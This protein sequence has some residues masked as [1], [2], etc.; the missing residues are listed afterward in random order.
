MN[1][2]E[3]AIKSRHSVRKYLTKEMD[4]QVLEEL[5]KLVLKINQKANLNFQ[6]ITNDS[7]PFSKYR[8]HYGRLNAQNYFALVGQNTSDLEEKCGYYG[9]SIVLKCQTLGLNTCWVAGTYCKSAV[10]CTILKGQR[11][12]ALIAFG[13]GENQGIEHK[14]KKFQD[15]SKTEAPV[16]IWYHKGIEYALL[17]PTALNGQ[18]FKFQLLQP[19]VVKITPGFGVLTR[20]D[21]GI[22]KYHF[23]LGAGKN[24]FLWKYCLIK[25]IM[26]QLNRIQSKGEEI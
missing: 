23:E 20:I 16:P 5:Q 19:N 6:M 22:V 7:N 21:L 14:R 2:I 12:V 13:Y 17:A 9:Q 25:T 26:I 4:V 15:V 18:K 10:T 3:E 1:S 11:L 8:F 24:N